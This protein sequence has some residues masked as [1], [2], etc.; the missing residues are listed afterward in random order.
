MRKNNFYVYML[1]CSTGELYT[2]HTV[3]L[4]R[5]IEAHNTGKGAKFTRSRIP[6]KLVYSEKYK[7]RKEAMHRE[8]QLKRKT[9]K[10][11]K[12]LIAKSDL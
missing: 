2:G 9:R 11:K 3:N 12:E 4:K 1:E 10:E 5:R 7:S 6:A 8:R